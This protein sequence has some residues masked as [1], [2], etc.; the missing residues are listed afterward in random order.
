MKYKS[1]ALWPANEKLYL[2]SVNN[3]TEDTHD[4]ESQAKC[5]CWRLEKDGFGGD[6]QI[7]PIK[8]WVEPVKE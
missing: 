4:T 6:R 8:T 1:I 7:F 3:Q 5:V 2:S